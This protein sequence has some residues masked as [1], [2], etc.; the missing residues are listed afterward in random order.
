MNGH[1][2]EE[3][4]FSSS[5]YNSDTESTQST[6]LGGST[7][8]KRRAFSGPLGTSNYAPTTSSNSSL[9]WRRNKS[10][11][12]H[13]S[14]GTDKTTS[15][16]SDKNNNDDYVEITLD[17][18]DSIVVHSFQAAG[19]ANNKDPELALLAKQTLEGKKSPS[20]WSSLFLN[21]SSHIWQVS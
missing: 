21:T 13:N 16:T 14:G 4:M 6:A 15:I 20:F 7:R 11:K 9:M 2:D 19:G 17:I 3:G 5:E 8:F 12:G 18:R 1:H 10:T